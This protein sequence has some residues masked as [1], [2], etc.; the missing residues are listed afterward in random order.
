[1]NPLRVNTCH[2]LNPLAQSSAAAPRSAAGRAP[3][4]APDA[5]HG[6]T[7]RGEATSR[8]LLV[9]RM[10]EAEW[11]AKIREI[12][13]LY[14]WFTYHTHNSKF[15]EKGWPDFVLGHPRRRRTIFAELKTETGKLSDA[16]RVWLTH[17]TACGFETALW[18]PS[19]MDTVLAVLG[20]AQRTTR[21][22]PR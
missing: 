6:G 21:W 14:N 13:A 19:D 10:T 12:A 2:D 3:L 1:V 18:R 8:R 11:T 15:S 16:Q 9:A 22:E 7:A 5:P 17:L 4:P 20:P